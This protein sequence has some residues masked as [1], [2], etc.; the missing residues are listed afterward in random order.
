M[1]HKNIATIQ[2][3][4]D[5]QDSF[6]HGDFDKQKVDDLPHLVASMTSNRP[7]VLKAFEYTRDC[8]KVFLKIVKKF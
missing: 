5:A 7:A 6:I 4:L 1:F 8:E 3:F 2:G